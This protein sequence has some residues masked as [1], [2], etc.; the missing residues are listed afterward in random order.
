MESIY[1][2][3]KELEREAIKRKKEAKEADENTEWEDG[4]LSALIDIESWVDANKRE[5]ECVTG[6][7]FDAVNAD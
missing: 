1:D 7:E 5:V 3:I 6:Y 4:Y 2:A